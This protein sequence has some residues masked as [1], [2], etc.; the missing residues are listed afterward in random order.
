[1]KRTVTLIQT[2]VVLSFALSATWSVAIP[3]R[4]TRIEPDFEDEFEP[5]NL[6]DFLLPGQV[7]LSV[8]RKERFCDL[9]LIYIYPI[10]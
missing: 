1:M 2:V 10:A 9:S 3:T 4:P 8:L 6:P 7:R 5:E